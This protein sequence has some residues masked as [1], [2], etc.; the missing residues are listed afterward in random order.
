MTEKKSILIISG[1]PRKD[2]NSERLSEAFQKGAE[3]AG[4][5]VSVFHLSQARVEPCLGCG[6]CHS[7]GG[8]CVQNDDMARILKQFDQA[9]MLVLTSPVY[10]FS[11]SAQLK[12]FIDRLYSRITRPMR[13]KQSVLLM[14]GNGDVAFSSMENHYRILC[15][16]MQWELLSVEGHTG[17]VT[18]EVLNDLTQKARRLLE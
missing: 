14:T 13:I 10:F 3:A 17:T 2:G 12:A 6:N 8:L 7:N 9:D 4:H 5:S 16:A 11:L 18:E 15:G 1:S